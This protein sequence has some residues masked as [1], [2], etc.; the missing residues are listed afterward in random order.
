MKTHFTHINFILLIGFLSSSL[1]NPIY[2]QFVP[3]EGGSLPTF[4]TFTSPP[5]KVSGLIIE[6]SDR[7]NYSF[8]GGTYAE[9][10]MTFPEPRSY[11]ADTYTLQYSDD[12]GTTWK[13]YQYNEKDLTTDFNNFVL[14]P[15]GYYKFR[16]L[17]NGGP[18]S[19]YTSNEEFAPLSAVLSKFTG[20]GMDESMWMTGVMAPYTGRGMEASLSVKDLLTKK[21]I[22]G[23]LTYQWFRMNPL[24][25]ETTKITGATNLKYVTTEADAGYHLGVV[26]TGDGVKVGGFQKI[27][28]CWENIIPNKCFASGVTNSGFTINL[29]KTTSGL[30]IE[31]LELSDNEYQE[32]PITSVQVGDNAAIYNISAQLSISKAPYALLHKNNFWRIVQEMDYG[33]G[34]AHMMSR[35]TIDF[36]TKVQ[37]LQHDNIS[38]LVRGKDLHFKSSFN[39]NQINIVDLT[40]KS[41]I[42]SNP[43]LMEGLL[44]IS[45]LDHG[46]FI[47][48]IS[49]NNGELNKKIAL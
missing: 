7:N 6:K 45:T 27:M 46:I 44:D 26:A 40:G 21:A 42:T 10:F 25:F 30:Q 29:F 5:N 28:A 18:K 32:V 14:S 24:T 20:W 31:D 19:G 1:S 33:G 43:Q 35:L 12:N 16:L 38:L 17:L 47:V 2:G 36:P 34:E 4:P 3:G 37:E 15:N 39:V 8:G 9:I 11:D 13:N 23:S 49:T 48:R 22:D 41:R